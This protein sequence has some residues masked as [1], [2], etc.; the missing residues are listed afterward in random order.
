MVMQLPSGPWLTHVTWTL[1]ADHSKLQAFI[2]TLYSAATGWRTQSTQLPHTMGSVAGREADIVKAVWHV[3]ILC[4]LAQS[5]GQLQQSTNDD[6]HM[7]YQEMVQK[8]QPEVHLSL[9]IPFAQCLPPTVPPQVLHICTTCCTLATTNI[10]RNCLEA[11][12]T[13][14]AQWYAEAPQWLAPKMTHQTMDRLC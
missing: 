10:E 5:T 12:T 11:M 3:R 9:C 6:S 13:T 7:I 2:Y 1:P 8:D 14:I 4:P